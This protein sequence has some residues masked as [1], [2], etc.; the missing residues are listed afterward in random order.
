MDIFEPVD[1]NTVSLRYLKERTRL[2]FAAMERGEVPDMPLAPGWF[3]CFICRREAVK[4][5]T[6]DEEQAEYARRFG[7][8]PD[9]GGQMVVCD[10]CN[11]IVAEDQG[12]PL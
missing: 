6:G 10:D 9:P 3:R 8:V 5:V 1:P 2:L 11:R 12:M 7:P 4:G